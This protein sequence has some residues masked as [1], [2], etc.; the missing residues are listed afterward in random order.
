MGQV[1]SYFANDD[2]TQ[3]VESTDFKHVSF[4]GAS[5]VPHEATEKPIEEKALAVDCGQRKRVTE[6]RADSPPFLQ[7]NNDMY[8]PSW[9]CCQRLDGSWEN[10]LVYGEAQVLGVMCDTVWMPN[11]SLVGTTPSTVSPA[12][13]ASPVTPAPPRAPPSLG[14]IATPEPPAPPER[15]PVL[16]P[17]QRRCVEAHEELSVGPAVVVDEAG[18]RVAA[19]FKPIATKADLVGKPVT[20]MELFHQ[21]NMRTSPMH[22]A[23]PLLSTPPPTVWPMQMC[24]GAEVYELSMWPAPAQAYSE[25]QIHEAHWQAQCITPQWTENALTTTTWTEQAELNFTTTTASASP[26]APVTDI[27][28]PS[29]SKAD[30]VEGNKEQRHSSIPPGLEGQQR[31][32]SRAELLEWREALRK[33]CTA[34]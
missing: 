27:V 21:P 15:G 10:R 29:P 1:T 9:Q 2:D 28:I 24:E 7:A 19:A 8:E 25:S 34:A 11:G 22:I 6:L 26:P 32:L 14:H 20:L 18:A 30:I 13:P 12:S 17:E 16:T 23:G 5:A 4:A 33:R 31:A 3:V